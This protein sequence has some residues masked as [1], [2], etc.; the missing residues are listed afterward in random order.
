M[1]FPFSVLNSKREKKIRIIDVSREISNEKDLSR[2][3]DVQLNKII[4]FMYI[5]PNDINFIM[6]NKNKFYRNNLAVLFLTLAMINDQH[7]IYTNNESYKKFLYYIYRI[8]DNG[9]GDDNNIKSNLIIEEDLEFQNKLF[10]EIEC[11]REKIMKILN[12]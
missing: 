12:P 4:D 2:E 3:F 7:Y 9:E 8:N 11:Y 10:F 1:S 5:D 6:S